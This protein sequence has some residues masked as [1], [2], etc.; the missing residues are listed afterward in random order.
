MLK[1]LAYCKRFVPDR[2]A[3]AALEFVLVAPFL[4]V[5]LFGVYELSNAL[6]IYQQTYSAAHFIAAAVTNVSV[7]ASGS[8]VLTYDQVQEAASEIWGDIPALRSGQQDDIKSV[9]VSSITFE[10]TS[11]KA[12]C[13]STACYTPVVA[14]S[15][16]YTGGDSG[17]T[18]QQ[19]AST[20]G[21]VT[22]TPSGSSTA[23]TTSI[24]TVTAPLRSCSNIASTPVT[25]SA[26]PGSLNQTLPSQGVSSDL[27][28][29][30]TLL[31]GQ[32]S[33]SSTT[34][35]PSP[36]IVVDVHLKYKP[37]FGFFPFS[38]DFWVNGYWPVR[39][40]KTTVGTTV[41]LYQQFTTISSQSLSNSNSPNYTDGVK[42]SINDYCVNTT[43]TNPSPVSTP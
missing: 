34:A 5:M 22:Y 24:I 33:S 16:V 30:R 6:I 9:T 26:W 28:S 2:R 42:R 12:S 1:L 36:I 7:Q 27:T 38:F 23:V 8:T 21:S 32:T 17:R 15:I 39:S 14:W 20:N 43:L 18:F 41:P 3:V 4:V 10:P 31:L 29:L 25:A 37:V 11:T 35:P 13:T 40:V 19:S